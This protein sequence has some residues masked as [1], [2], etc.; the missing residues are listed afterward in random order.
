MTK[1]VKIESRTAEGAPV[2]MTVQITPWLNL[3]NSAG[4]GSGSTTKY[5]G[6]PALFQSPHTEQARGR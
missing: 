1:T 3:P 6:A 2:T 5:I 4:A